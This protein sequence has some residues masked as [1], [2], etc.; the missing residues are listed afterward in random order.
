METFKTSPMPVLTRLLGEADLSQLV[1]LRECILNGIK[2]SELYLREDDEFD[3]LTKHLALSGRTVGVFKDGEL[4]AYGIVK[5]D[6][7]PIEGG[8]LSGQ[9]NLILRITKSAIMQSSMVK[10]EYR[11]LG[12]QGHLLRFR[13]RIGRER[14][15]E[16]MF[17]QVSLAN[18]YSRENLLTNRYVIVG[19]VRHSNGSVRHVFAKSIDRSFYSCDASSTGTWVDAKNINE[20]EQLFEKGFVAT[21]DDFSERLRFIKHNLTI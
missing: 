15:C 9:F 16:T 1:N 19:I 11:G 12:L 14:G 17:S 3:F 20:Q 2:S 8:T 4:I 6:G 13:E 21:R 18:S 5:L 10:K 7:D